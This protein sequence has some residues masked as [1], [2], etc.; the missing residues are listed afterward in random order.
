M[1]RST[2]PA[3]K[4]AE[5][6]DLTRMQKGKRSITRD[7]NTFVNEISIEILTNRDEEWKTKFERQ[8]RSIHLARGQT[9]RNILTR[10][11]S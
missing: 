3:V 8:D 5:K 10:A 11:R 9:V 7:V 4:A 1:H 2:D 6:A